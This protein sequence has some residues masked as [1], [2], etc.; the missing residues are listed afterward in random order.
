[1]VD[2]EFW[3][4]PKVWKIMGVG[5]LL[6]L[7]GVTLRWAGVDS[8]LEWT[9]ALIGVAIVMVSTFYF[10]F[11]ENWVLLRQRNRRG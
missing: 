1:M 6:I 8:T 2:W 4:S 5:F 11:W 10:A 3:G 9:L 7:L